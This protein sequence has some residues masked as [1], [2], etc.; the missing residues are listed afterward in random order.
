[1]KLMDEEEP[2]NLGEAIEW[3]EEQQKGEGYGSKKVEGKTIKKR[4]IVDAEAIDRFSSDSG[5]LHL[6]KD[7]LCDSLYAINWYRRGRKWNKTAIP[8]LI[9]TKFDDFVQLPLEM[10]W[11]IVNEGNS[12]VHLAKD[13]EVQEKH[14]LDL[15]NLTLYTHPFKTFQL[16]LFPNIFASFNDTFIH[17][18]N[19]SGR[20]TLVRIT[21]ISGNNTIRLYFHNLVNL[22]VQFLSLDPIS[23]TSTFEFSSFLKL[24]F[25]AYY[26][27]EA[28]SKQALV[29]Q[30]SFNG[31]SKCAGGEAGSHGMKLAVGR[32][33]HRLWGHN[34]MLLRGGGGASGG[35]CY[36]GMELQL[37]AATR[38]AAGA[39]V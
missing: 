9:G 36:A 14:R 20:E 21:D 11:T 8:V 39:T 2:P 26:K 19:L 31:K 15:E 32:S 33:W 25:R 34:W 12:Q 24:D 1:M 4:R 23:G 38:E 16:F 5:R 7:Q 29:D 17:V 37:G 30:L 3:K 27:S 18:T 28:L 13:S 22:Q 6:M 35:H 10:Q